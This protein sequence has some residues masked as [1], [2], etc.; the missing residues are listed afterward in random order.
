MNKW[1][2]LLLG[3]ILVVGVIL[4]AWASSAYNWVFFGK[5]F[6][7]LHSAWF[8]FKGG[9]FWFLIMIGSLLIILGI[10]DLRD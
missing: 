10:N 7:F 2:E 9:L 4:I 8:F 5:D 1:V 3:L 6:N